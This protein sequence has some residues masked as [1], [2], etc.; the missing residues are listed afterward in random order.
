LFLLKELH[1]SGDNYFD[2][3]FCL[4]LIS[5]LLS[6]G[7][8]IL[9]LF[10]LLINAVIKCFE[11]SSSVFSQNS[12]II[13]I[14]LDLFRTITFLIDKLLNS[15]VKM[16]NDNNKNSSSLIRSSSSC[17]LESC[18]IMSFRFCLSFTKNVENLKYGDFD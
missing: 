16:K 11:S 13:S 9:I 7:N 14:K 10:S 6:E 12:Y 2:S 4:P 17:K 15:N 3:L 1:N 5:I 8:L 18:I